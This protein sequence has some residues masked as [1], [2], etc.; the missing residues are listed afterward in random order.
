MVYGKNRFEMHVKMFCF[1]RCSLFQ[2]ALLVTKFSCLS[3]QTKG[4]F[5]HDQKKLAAAYW[6]KIG[7]MLKDLKIM[8]ILHF[9]SFLGILFFLTSFD[10]DGRLQL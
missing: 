3:E 6:S 1:E 4:P 2:P 9:S 5:A 8:F 7:A 10:K